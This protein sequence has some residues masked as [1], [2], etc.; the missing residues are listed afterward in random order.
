MSSKTVRF[1]NSQNLLLDRLQGDAL[2]ANAELQQ[3]IRLCLGELGVPEGK[4][5]NFDDVL[6]NRAF[7]WEVDDASKQPD[8]GP[9]VE[10]V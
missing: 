6:R 3:A 9:E 1:L 10:G 4:T 2:R 5:F 8:H 7:T